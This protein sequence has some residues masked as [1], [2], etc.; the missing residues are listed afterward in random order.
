MNTLQNAKV[1]EPSSKLWFTCP[2]CSSYSYFESHCR[3]CG[4]RHCTKCVNVLSPN[5]EVS[6]PQLCE[7]IPT[8]KEQELKAC[9]K[10][11]ESSTRR[12][13]VILWAKLLM[14][15]YST[16]E[17]C[18]LDM[19]K[20]LVQIDVP[21]DYV[22]H[23]P[24]SLRI[25]ARCLIETHER[26][27]TANRFE[28][29]CRYPEY[30]AIPTE[31]QI[32]EKESNLLYYD[33]CHRTNKMHL[34]ERGDTRVRLTAPLFLM[35]TCTVA[36]YKKDISR[37]IIR[38]FK[39]QLASIYHLIDERYKSDLNSH[40]A[41]V[42]RMLHVPNQCASFGS[43]L[44][45][46]MATQISVWKETAIGLHNAV[47]EFDRCGAL[48]PETCLPLTSSDVVFDLKKVHLSGVSIAKEQTTCLRLTLENGYQTICYDDVNP[49]FLR[50]ATFIDCEYA[51]H[52][53]NTTVASEEVT[54][55]MMRKDSSS[56]PTI[57][58]AS[59]KSQ[60][61]CAQILTVQGFLENR[62]IRF[63]DVNFTVD[64]NGLLIVLG[65]GGTD[66]T[67]AADT[68]ADTDDTTAAD[69][70][71][72]TDDAD[73]TT[74]DTTAANTTETT[75]DSPTAR[76]IDL[77]GK[78]SESFSSREY[79]YW[80]CRVMGGDDDTARVFAQLTPYVLE[81]YMVYDY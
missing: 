55:F 68:A 72:T 9:L 70:A 61:V 73:D 81:Q 24:T 33:I 5:L 11:T 14:R 79:M 42:E 74:A 37:C 1:W 56:Q 6:A 80:L 21:G 26:C 29:M 35:L 65:T 3:F 58:I 38:K 43:G 75:E 50:A 27:V 23:V 49:I 45:A 77:N 63:K 66:D 71:D 30:R 19:W 4:L 8:D 64:D 41:F 76:S 36:N 46:V 12:R 40:I 53:K 51:K 48:T 69:A 28:Y 39:S 10:C 25:A 52:F 7:G 22:V 34:L 16:V 57:C 18:G 13:R 60:L 78:L 44:A 54:I 59:L 62:R 2:G 32:V 67:T 31:Q 17:G 15:W 47:Q 20:R